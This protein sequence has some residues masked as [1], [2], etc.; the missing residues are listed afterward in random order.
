[1]TLDDK[2][3]N[4]SSRQELSI[5]MLKV[6]EIRYYVFLGH[7][8]VP[9]EP[10]DLTLDDRQLNCSSRQKL[11][12]GMLKVPQIKFLVFFYSLVFTFFDF[13]SFSGSSY[14]AQVE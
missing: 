10:I 3:L 5:G 6:S 12:I 7:V 4:C 13:D 1:L 14:M 9:T 11:S 2:Q 8:A